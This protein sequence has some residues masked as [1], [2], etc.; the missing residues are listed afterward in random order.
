M[1]QKLNREIKSYSRISIGNSDKRFQSVDAINRFV[2]ETGRAP[3]DWFR[4]QTLNP[5]GM[6]DLTA[7]EGR[8]RLQVIKT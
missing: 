7:G 1:S 2:Q 3:E 5:E 4:Y 8:L 6:D